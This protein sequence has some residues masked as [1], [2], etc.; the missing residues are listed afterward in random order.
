MLHIVN[1]WN[2]VQEASADFRLFISD[3]TID[4]PALFMTNS[5]FAPFTGQKRSFENNVG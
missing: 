2:G 4:Y 3:M 5:A 1:Y